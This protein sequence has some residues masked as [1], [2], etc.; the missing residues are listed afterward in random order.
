MTPVAQQ[1]EAAV[2]ATV[3]NVRALIGT[4]AA[5]GIAQAQ[6]AAACLQALAGQA[7]LWDS[8]DFPIPEG[9]RWQ[10]Y[11]LHE[12]ADGGYAMYAVAM[13]PGHAQ[14]PHDH[15]TWAL[16]AGVRG[17]ERN[18]LYRRPHATGPAPL[19]HLGD[20][21]VAAHGALA[22]GPSDIHAIE[23][24]GPGDA[25]HLHLYGKGFAHLQERRIFDPFTSESRAFPAIQNVA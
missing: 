21:T 20:I 2:Q 3:A 14:P 9:K 10:A 18:S 19:G 15:T 24:L 1:R 25:L 22:L 7:T 6:C 8:R 12:D 5:P 17:A 23:V 4:D 16:I 11:T 13:H